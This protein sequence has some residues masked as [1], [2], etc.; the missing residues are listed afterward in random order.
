MYNILLSLLSQF[1]NNNDPIS[2][3]PRRESTSSLPPYNP[4]WAN[5]T[6][7]GSDANSNSLPPVEESPPQYEIAI[8]NAE[9]QA[10]WLPEENEFNECINLDVLFD[11]L[12]GVNLFLCA[13]ISCQK[14]NRVDNEA[15]TPSNELRD[16]SQTVIAQPQQGATTGSIPN[17]S[18][19]FFRQSSD[20]NENNNLHI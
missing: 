16:S 2:D 20:I 11:L 19:L 10:Q 14:N 5:Q 13:L 1:A 12:P 4:E 18:V 6:M 8:Q 15:N 3:Q 17:N 9:R 7:N